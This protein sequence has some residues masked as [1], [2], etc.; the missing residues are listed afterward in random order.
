[1]VPFTFHFL[2]E[3]R[4]EFYVTFPENAENQKNGSNSLKILRFKYIASN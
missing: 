4:Y 2:L 3:T 1:M